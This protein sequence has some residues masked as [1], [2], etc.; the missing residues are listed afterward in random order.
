MIMKKWN[1]LFV[2]L[3][4]AFLFAFTVSSVTAAEEVPLKGKFIGVGNDFSGHMT[5]LGR[6]TGVID[7]VAFTAVWT[8]ANGDTVTN[9]TTSFV[10]VEEVKPGVFTYE[11]TL[12]ITGGTGRFENATGDAFVTGLFNVVTGQ[13]NG[14]LTGTI[15]QPNS[16]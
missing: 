15:S 11:Q 10:L 16:G 9:Q 6:F 14:R 13:Y 3:F 7:P 2:L 12:L 5:H 4:F 8:A 1:R